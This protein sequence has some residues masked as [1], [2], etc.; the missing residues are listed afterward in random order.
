VDARQ[1]LCVHTNE[2]VLLARWQLLLMKALANS[3]A[4]CHRSG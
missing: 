1:V 2:V 3:K 4:S